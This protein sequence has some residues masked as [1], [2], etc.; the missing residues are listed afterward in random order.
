MEPQTP[1]PKSY[2]GRVL[3]LNLGLVVLLHVG[4]ELLE[5]TS[6]IYGAL[7]ALVF[8]DFVMALL[9]RATRRDETALACLL[10]ALLVGMAGFSDC[11]THFHLDTR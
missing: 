5:P 8:V 10:A 9:C 1:K 2:F 7:F 6:G 11:A 3:L 4:R